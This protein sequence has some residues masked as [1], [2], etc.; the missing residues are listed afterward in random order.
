VK[1][2]KNTKAKQIENVVDKS[3]FHQVNMG[4]GGIF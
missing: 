2:K 4:G 1:P 3:F